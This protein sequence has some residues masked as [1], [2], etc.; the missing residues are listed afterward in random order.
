MKLDAKQLYVNR[1]FKY[2]LPCLY[3]FGNQFVIKYAGTVKYA[4]GIGDAY[5]VKEKDERWVF[6]LLNKKRETARF[7]DFL[8]FTRVQ[9]YYVR[10]YP[11]DNPSSGMHMIVVKLPE[12]CHETYDKFVEGKYSEMYTEEQFQ[13]LFDKKYKEG[14]KAHQVWQESKKVLQKSPDAIPSFIKQIQEEFGHDIRLSRKDLEGKE[15]DF[16]ISYSMETEIFNY[17]AETV[18]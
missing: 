18:L 15:L 2:L 5:I 9:K 17:G 10:D 8:N 7:Q 11:Y 16:P 6:L 14:V 13:N 12:Q 3:E 1:T 4:V